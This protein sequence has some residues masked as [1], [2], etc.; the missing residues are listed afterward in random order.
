[1]PK[2]VRLAEASAYHKS[3]IC[4][5]SEPEG[6][7]GSEEPHF[8]SPVSRCAGWSPTEK[9]RQEHAKFDQ[10]YAEWLTS[11]AGHICPDSNT[12]GDDEAQR[13]LDREEELARLI[14]TAPA[15][16]PWMVFQKFEVLEHYLG[17]EHG[18]GWRDNRELVMLAGIK[19]DLLRF[20]LTE[21]K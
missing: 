19:A 9:Q 15:V 18:T 5:A 2:A 4:K 16:F 10:L 6:R 12:W 7:L 3:S 17:S 14:T 8:S 20:E 11:R 1:M 21:E 13:C